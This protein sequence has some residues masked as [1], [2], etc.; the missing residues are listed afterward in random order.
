M[1]GD[2]E[3][4]IEDRKWGMV[5]KL[6]Q[7]QMPPC[8]N[9]QPL[10]DSPMPTLKKFFSAPDFPSDEMSRRAS[11]LSFLLNLHII[12]SA[13]TTILSL[14]FFESFV[15]SAVSFIGCLLGIGMRLLLRRNHL[16]LTSGLFVGMVFLLMPAVALASGSSASSAVMTAFQLMTVVMAGLLLGGTFAWIFIALTIAVNGMLIYA[17]MNGFYAVDINRDPVFVWVMQIITFSAVAAMLYLA[18][19]LIRHSF[20]VLHESERRFFSFMK[21]TTDGIMF[22]DNRGRLT[23]WNEAAE[24]L[25]GVSKQQV[26]GLDALAIQLQFSPE[27]ERKDIDVDRLNR[28]MQNVLTTGEVDLA[29]QMGREVRLQR[30]DG[31]IRIVEQ[32]LFSI[33]AVGGFGLGVTLQDVTKRRQAEQEVHLLNTELEQR[34]RER[35]AQLEAA[36][37]ELEAFSYS[38]SHDL[39]APLRSINSF[40]KILRDDF[41]ADLNPIGR[42]F[43]DRVIDSSRKMNQLIDELL[44]FSRVNRKEISRRIVDMNDLVREVIESLATESSDRVIAWSVSDLPPLEADPT[45]MRQVF[46]NLISNA[47]KYTRKRDRAEIEIGCADGAYFVRDNGAGFDMQYADKL[48]GVFQ[49]LHRDDEFEGV[50]IGLAI[51]QRIIQRHGGQV[52]AEAKPDEGAVFYF[53]LQ[54]RSER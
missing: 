10:K 1:I 26:L 2:D 54:N 33:Q 9:V 24:N 17:E 16:L 12:V 36:N 28:I 18:N 38:V 29:S 21:G 50:G 48:F 43:L 51:I 31:S 5:V 47:I 46:V 8:F 15:Y 20:Q 6:R 52:W 34:V 37:R 45:L 11:L 7:A 44:D 42:G 25:T 13:G 4:L 53:T 35:T 22:F 39:R 32:K 41:S 49:R 23:A 30:A 40:T 19:R 27:D 3:M 14:V